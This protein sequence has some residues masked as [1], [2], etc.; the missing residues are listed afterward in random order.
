[1][2]AHRHDG[3]PAASASQLVTCSSDQLVRGNVSDREGRVATEIPDGTS[4]PVRS[5]N[6][7]PP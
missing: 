4:A 6:V 1:M 5:R 7:K 2:D 3:S